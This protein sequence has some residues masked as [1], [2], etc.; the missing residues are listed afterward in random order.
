MKETSLEIIFKNCID[1]TQ[2]ERRAKFT[3]EFH[4]FEALLCLSH[5]TFHLNFV[6]EMISKYFKLL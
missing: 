3:I 5:L 6:K 2:N 4:K 1:R